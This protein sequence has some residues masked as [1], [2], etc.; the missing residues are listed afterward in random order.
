MP[1]HRCL[2]A[3]CALSVALPAQFVEPT[4]VPLFQVPGRAT[5]DLFGWRVV[6]LNDADT[7]RVPDFAVAAPFHNL[8]VGRISLHSGATGTERWFRDET[9]TSAVFGF[10]MVTVRDLDRDGVREVV[11]SAPF[12]GTGRVVVLSGRTGATL[13]TLTPPTGGD[14]FGVA[15]AAGGDYDGDGSE[16][17]VVAD[18]SN[19]TTRVNGGQLFLYALP[20]VAPPRAIPPT[21]TN[22][23][24]GVSLAFVGDTDRDGRDE[25]AVGD[26]NTPSSSA[27]RLHVM[28]WNGSADVVRWTVA[29]VEF[30]SPIDGNRFAGGGDVDGDGA[31]DLIVDEGF[32]TDRARLFSGAN[33]NVLRTFTDSAGGRCGRGATIVA[34]QNHDGV[35]DLM[36]GAASDSSVAQWNGRFLLFSGRDGRRL[37]QYTGTTARA[38]FGSAALLGPD[39]TNDGWPELIVAARGASGT[40]PSMGAVHVLRGDAGLA[41]WQ[42]YGAGWPGANGVPGLELAADPVLGTTWPIAMTSSA[43]VP[44]IGLLQVGGAPQATPSPWGFPLL[45]ASAADLLVILPG[46]TS[47]LPIHLPVDPGLRGLALFGQLLVLDAGASAGVAASPGL[48][49]TLGG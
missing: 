24:F 12:A 48:R 49:L 10:D 34:D 39:L 3:S 14:A 45:V 37:L 46:G 25:L 27:G 33:G 31:P 13:Y 38:L 28:G 2:L 29:G 42:S 43:A 21:S 15:L 22:S 4:A 47:P 35:P 40:S 17:L 18:D 41:G 8:N 30:G 20:P 23:M 36:M 5:G 19:D 11:A 26:R 9:V 1:S 16:D 7:D 44:T 6:A 32:P